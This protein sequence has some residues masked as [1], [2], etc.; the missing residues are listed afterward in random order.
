MARA[1]LLAAAVIARAVI[2][3]AQLAAMATMS[4]SG[5]PLMAAFAADVAAFT[6]ERTRKQAGV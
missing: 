6:A 4:L 5:R 1:L 2:D 3:P